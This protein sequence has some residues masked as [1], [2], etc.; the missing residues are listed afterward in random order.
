MAQNQKT[1]SDLYRQYRELSSD[2]RDNADAIAQF[3]ANRVAPTECQAQIDSIIQSLP[4]ASPPPESTVRRGLK[5]PD[6]LSPGNLLKPAVAVAC[7]A[8]VIFTI[9]YQRPYSWDSQIPADLDAAVVIDSIHSSIGGAAQL[10]FMSNAG[11]LGI[12]YR[13]GKT[14]VQLALSMAADNASLMPYFVATFDQLAV[15]TSTATYH[16]EILKLAAT[17]SAGADDFTVGSALTDLSSVFE[18]ENTAR[19][20]GYVLGRRI[21]SLRLALIN[22]QADGK[23]QVVQ[24]AGAAVASLDL[25][26]WP[27]EHIPLLNEL[28]KKIQ[29]LTDS[30][31]SLEDRRQLMR[32]IEQLDVLLTR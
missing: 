18:S 29:T 31:Y 26:Q 11:A 5:W 7:A 9:G 16:E 27:N 10:G 23:L 8:G 3:T 22:A 2:Q 28:L 19:V 12:E 25:Q 24:N 1:P 17:L 32:Y 6:W 15:H 13:L 30:S 20:E 4:V 14:S 21:E